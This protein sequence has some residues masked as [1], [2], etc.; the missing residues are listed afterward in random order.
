MPSSVLAK[1]SWTSESAGQSRIAVRCSATASS[2]FSWN[3]RARPRSECG[4]WW[5]GLSRT[6]CAE[7]PD[8]LIGS[9]MLA[10]G[11][12]EIDMSPEVIGIETNH[13]AFQGNGLL[14]PAGKVVSD[15]DCAAGG[16]LFR[17]DVQGC[18]IR[19]DGLVV[20]SLLAERVAEA[21]EEQDAPGS[22]GDGRGVVARGFF[23]TVEVVPIRDHS[24]VEVDPGIIRVVPPAGQEHSV[25][26]L[27]V[28]VFR[29]IEVPQRGCQKDDVRD[30]L[31]GQVLV[32]GQPHECRPVRVVNLVAQSGAPRVRVGNARDG[33]EA[34][35]LRLGS[36]PSA[37]GPG[38]VVECRGDGYRR[39]PPGD[40]RAGFARIHRIQVQPIVTKRVRVFAQDADLVQVCVLNAAAATDRIE[41][42][43]IARSFS[44]SSAAARWR[45]SSARSRR[46][47][48]FKAGS[49]SPELRIPSA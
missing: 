14:V 42:P 1:R 36:T 40:D 22:S 24:Q 37:Q 32:F 10:Q 35:P 11:C 29:A 30:R 47:R 18:L 3:P 15:R 38:P 48:T 46:T 28:A 31:G 17:V 20:P 21:G 27:E 34:P 19:G 9:A 2:N 4:R 49:D 25:S 39:W 26:T 43:T 8:R 33:I 12:A 13:V 44:A 41:A 45:L 23:E 5:L 6:A 16:V 7:L